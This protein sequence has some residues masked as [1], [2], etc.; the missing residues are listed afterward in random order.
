MSELEEPEREV[1]WVQYTDND[2]GSAKFTVSTED[3]DHRFAAASVNGEAV[4]SYEETL[5]WRG[6][7][8]VG[9][10]NEEVYRKLMTSDGMTAFLE[11]YGLSGVVRKR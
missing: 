10:P 4:V 6:V 8:R 3:E 11:Q 2:D 7:I 1:P 9:D 5:S